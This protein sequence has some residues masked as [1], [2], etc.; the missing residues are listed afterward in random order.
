MFSFSENID[1][2]TYKQ[3]LI[4]LNK[5]FVDSFFL[6]SSFKAS[7]KFILLDLKCNWI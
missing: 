2:N 5:T 4:F 1:Y 7:C 3:T 6:K